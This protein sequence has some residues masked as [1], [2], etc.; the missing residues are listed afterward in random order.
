MRL[1]LRQ[2]ANVPPCDWQTT[3]QKRNNNWSSYLLFVSPSGAVPF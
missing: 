2:Y 1:T 3:A